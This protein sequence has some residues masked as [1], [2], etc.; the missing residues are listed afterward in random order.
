MQHAGAGASAA[1]FP[2]LRGIGAADRPRRVG[3]LDRGAIV[4][5]VTDI[6]ISTVRPR[7]V[8]VTGMTGPDS[9]E[10]GP[11]FFLPGRHS[12]RLRPQTMMKVTMAAATASMM[13][14]PSH[15]IVCIWEMGR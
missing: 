2:G 13:P 10:S 4:T 9:S 11:D 8:L 14:A 5:V 15:C 7:Q 1:W 3:D 12:R 6:E